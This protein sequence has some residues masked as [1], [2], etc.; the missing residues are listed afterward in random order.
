MEAERVNAR[1]KG[2]KTGRLMGGVS[3]VDSGYAPA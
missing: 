2:A 1:T 3:A